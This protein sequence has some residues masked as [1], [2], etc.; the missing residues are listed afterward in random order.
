[1]RLLR[2]AVVFA[3][4]AAAIVPLPA[5]L[6]EAWYS[7]RIYP[8]IQARLTPF[9]NAVAIALL[10][11]AIAI[12]AVVLIVALWRLVRSVGVGRA[13]VRALLH[14]LAVASAVY[15]V[16][17]LLWGLN[18]RRAPIET[19]LD[20]DAG[21]ITQGAARAL[22]ER[23]ARLANATYSGGEGGPTLEEAFTQAQQILKHERLAVPGVPKTS[24]LG[25]YFRAAA[26]DGMTDPFFL[27]VILNPDALPF[28]RP[29]I[30]AHEWAHLAGYAHE[31]EANLVAWLTCMQGSPQAQYSGW[32][33][34][35][36]HVSAS[37]PRDDRKA[38][39]ALLDA[40]PRRDL[41]EA[42]K[43]YGKSTPMVRD[44]ARD[45]YDKYLRANRVDEG[46]ASYSA[47]VRLLL[48]AGVHQGLA[49]RP[50][51]E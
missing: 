49:L 47:V 29:F 23:A 24:L 21:R 38:L 26:I 36:E 46:V 51:P 20:F 10:D 14:L 48:G 32:L 43:R 35:F 37:A 17:L 22:G 40:G 33:A 11:V 5:A 13:L 4:L 3:A 42:A 15:L 6:V 9:S 31:A 44:T 19:K 41:A 30:L 34:I 25:L 12:V 18:Y 8:A 16:F 7:R 28:E 45:V 1:M 27:E 50:R 2:V 39:F